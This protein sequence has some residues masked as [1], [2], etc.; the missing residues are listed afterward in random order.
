[1]NTTRIQRCATTLL[2]LAVVSC[3]GGT[4][5]LAPSFVAVHNTM[6]AMGLVQSGEISEGS[7]AEGAVARFPT[8]FRGGDCYMVVA[9]GSDGVANLDVL[10]TDDAG[11]EVAA[12]TSSDAQAAA[13]FCPESDGEYQVAVRMASGN[14]GYVVTSWSGAPRGAGGGAVA[15]GGGGRGTCSQPLAL[16]IG[17]PARGNTAQGESSMAGS[18]I[19]G[20]AAP[21]IVYRLTLAR[22][23]QVSVTLSSEF[24]GALYML[25]S[26]GDARSEIAC[27]D[28]DPDTTRSRV[29]ATLDAGTYFV[30]VDGYA[31][32][33]GEFELLAQITELQNLAQ[34]CQRATVL[35]PGQAV[36]GSTAGQP[37]Y[38]TATCA[39]GARS[40]DRIY[41]VDVPARSRMRV[42]MQSTHDGALYMRS[43]CQNP[44]SE[45]ACNDDH[46]DT[47]HSMVVATVDPGRYFVYAD[48]F[49]QGNAGD[50]SLR[51]DLAPL[52]GGSAAADN[53]TA[54]GTAAPGTDL[55]LDTFAAADD[56][57]GSCGGQG[58][59]DVVYRLDFTTRVRVRARIADTEFP[60]AMYI[61]RQCGQAAS[62]VVC[63]AGGGGGGGA[64]EIDATLQ[65]GTYFL[66]VDGVRP[67]SFGSAR[68]ELALEDLQALDRA[69]QQAPRLRP[70][71]TV[72]GDT[73]SS[74]NRF[75]ATCASGARS[76]DLVYQLVLTQRSHVVI[77][78]TQQYDGVLHI[79]RDCSDPATELACNDDEGD[80][81]HS[82]VDTVLDR[83]TYYVVV[84]GFA[85][86]NQGSF[87]MDVQVTSGR[88]MPT[89]TPTPPTPPG[90]P[91]PGPTPTLRSP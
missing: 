66:V 44:S 58:A 16:E 84:D 11:T 57:T 21:E 34:V 25:G 38:F 61:Q 76:N 80:N 3:G 18:C 82:R 10:V 79:R 39:D 75:H 8:Q 12:D 5:R 7:L 20:G 14:G 36:T 27:N 87:T 41:R 56:L 67:D 86:N 72:T 62:E 31:D 33:S 48:G 19:R 17:T 22:R 88:G 54:P 29:E 35:T 91:T 53:C 81:R 15:R 63:G 2:A 60:A 74:T 47:Q 64:A 1:M 37:S 52:T 68:V 13:Q 23:A 4:L 46:R 28:D 73:S 9:F 78:T 89:P 85:N 49:S 51:A 42:R 6:T 32:A 65:P 90:T 24:D 45:L 77:T 69:C 50:F 71:R 26:C 59:P 55:E 30:V 83:G 40:P 43:D 70:G